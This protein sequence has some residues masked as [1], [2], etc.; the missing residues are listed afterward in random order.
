MGIPLSDRPEHIH[1]LCGLLGLGTP[2]GA[3]APVTG[4]FHHRVWRL[5]TDLGVFAIKQLAPD[6]DL[7]DPQVV[8]HYNATE[9]AAEKFASLGIGA[10][11]AISSA[12]NYLQLIAAVAYLV[13]PWTQARALEKDRLSRSHALEV[14]R[15]LARMHRADIFIPGLAQV[16][17]DVV[18][19]GKIEELVG[20]AVDRDLPDAALL[21]S[22]LPRF[23]DIAKRHTAALP[24]L[25]RKLVVSHGDLDQKNVLWNEQ[26][27]PVL[28]DW[29]SARRL[30]PTCEALLEA[31]DWS[32]I[33]TDF[34][35][36]LFETFLAAYREA[37]GVIDPDA[38][39]P[40][41]HCILGDW[42]D[43]L[44]YNVGRT[45][46]IDDLEQR[47]IGHAQIAFVLPTLLRLE[48]LTPDLLS[49]LE[50]TAGESALQA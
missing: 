46:M 17:A 41:L 5:Q 4:G 22:Q 18:T 50:A 21:R 7:A 15:L 39:E 2:Q 47:E 34:R 42:L 33:T 45:V 49:G 12:G 26:G 31:L 19:V 24:V 10:I 43:W 13:Y 23:I 48:G 36:D 27:E 9:A 40:A 37:G 16:Q 35:H 11:H 6:T 30:N 28:I 32:G 25:E 44:M 29:E 20:L 1:H 8:A 38:I 14:A 3:L